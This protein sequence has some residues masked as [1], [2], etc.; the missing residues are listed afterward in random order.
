MGTKRVPVPNLLMGNEAFSINAAQADN[1]LH[2]EYIIFCPA[3]HQ[4]HTRFM[5]GV[6]A[7][8]D[9]LHTES[10]KPSPCGMTYPALEKHMASESW[11]RTKIVTLDAK[12]N[13]WAERA[14]TFTSRETL[15]EHILK[16]YDDHAHTS[17]RMVVTLTW[18]GGQHDRTKETG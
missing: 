8:V 2:L 14:I 6:L 13:V 12:G 3:C 7:H 10:V 16:A 18:P 17:V 11:F 4:Y 9:L 1:L 15:C 5:Q